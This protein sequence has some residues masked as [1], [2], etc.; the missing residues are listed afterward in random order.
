VFEHLKVLDPLRK[1]RSYQPYLYRLANRPAVIAIQN[2]VQNDIEF[3]AA[4]AAAA[5]RLN[6]MLTMLLHAELDCVCC[7]YMVI[8]EH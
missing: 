1:M 7:M 6:Y 8:Q 2:L 3:N 4:V 5:Y